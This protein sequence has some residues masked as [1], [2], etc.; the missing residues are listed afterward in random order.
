M[1]DSPD[2]VFTVPENAQLYVMEASDNKIS[3]DSVLNNAVIQL[4]I[5]VS[6]ELENISECEMTDVNDMIHGNYDGWMDQDGS[7]PGLYDENGNV[8]TDSDY[9]SVT[10]ALTSEAQSVYGAQ[11]S[12]AQATESGLTGHVQMMQQRI[13]AVESFMSKVVGTQDYTASLLQTPLG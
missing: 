9:I 2:A 6:N 5:T 10:T 7:D 11:T 8:T 12:T 4:A 1:A 3:A 13:Q